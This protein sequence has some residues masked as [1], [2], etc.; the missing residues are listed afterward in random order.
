NAFSHSS[1]IH[2]DGILKNRQ[3]YEIISPDVIGLSQVKLNLTSRSGRAAVKHYMDKMGYSEQEY[4]INTLY[5]NFL[6]L[7]DKKG[8]VFEYDLEILAFIHDSK[9]KM[10]HFSL[11]DYD[12]QCD[13]NGLSTASIKLL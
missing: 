7:A 1:G 2:Q 6:E 12:V 13:F 4:N 11:H 3:N 10:E 8:Q 5:S 9:E